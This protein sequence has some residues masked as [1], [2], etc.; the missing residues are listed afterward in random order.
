M[1]NISKK[2]GEMFQFQ[3]LQIALFVAQKKDEEVQNEGYTIP[4]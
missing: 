2:N 4:R 3:A 1:L